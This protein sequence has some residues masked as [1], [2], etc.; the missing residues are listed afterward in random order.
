MQDAERERGWQNEE[1]AAL[2]HKMSTGM[3]RATQINGA[4][5]RKEHL[6]VEFSNFDWLTIVVDECWGSDRQLLACVIL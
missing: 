6:R 4:E 3:D 2:N 1:I 5:E